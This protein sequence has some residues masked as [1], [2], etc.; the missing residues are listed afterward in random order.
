MRLQSTNEVL[1]A[2]RQGLFDFWAVL[3]SSGFFF[4]PVILAR[5]HL[6]P[7]AAAL[8]LSSDCSQRAKNE[9]VLTLTMLRLGPL[10]AADGCPH[11][12]LVGILELA[13]LAVLAFYPL[14]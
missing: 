6:P 8:L 10:L 2:Y 11:L 9:S 14:L 5:L 1:Y 3:V 4:S 13:L 12:S 7:V